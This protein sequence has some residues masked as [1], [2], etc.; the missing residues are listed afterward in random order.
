VSGKAPGDVVRFGLRQRLEHS[1]VMVLFVVLAATGFPQ[2]FPET[3][4]AGWLVGVLGG[5]GAVRWLHRASGLLFAAL[6]VSHLAAAVV[7]TARGRSSLAMVPTR[8]DFRDVVVMLRYYLGLSPE[9]ARFD[10]FDYREKFEYWGLVFGA[11]IMSG[12]GLVLLYPIPF[13]SWVSGE[14]IPVAKVAHSQEGLLAFLVVLI[15]HLYNVHLAPEVFP[16]NTSIFTGRIS[17]DHLRQDHPLEYERLFPGEP[18]P[19]APGK[20]PQP[21]ERPDRLKAAGGRHG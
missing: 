4:W 12:T 6:A 1:A 8:K 3:A 7:A 17:R 9:R 10:R 18:P 11:L 14:L 20:E 16:F 21:E 5:I 2:K 19:G 15:W 13:A